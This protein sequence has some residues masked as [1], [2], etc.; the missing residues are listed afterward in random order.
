MVCACV[1]HALTELAVAGAWQPRHARS[2][3]EI[4]LKGEFKLG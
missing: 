3:T 4:T 1:G 2:Q